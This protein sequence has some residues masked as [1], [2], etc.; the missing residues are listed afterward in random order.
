MSLGTA[1]YSCAVD[2][3]RGAIHFFS[4]PPSVGRVITRHPWLIESLSG[5]YPT[6]KGGRRKNVNRT[7]RL[8]SI[9]STRRAGSC[10]L[11]GTAYSQCVTQRLNVYYT[12]IKSW[13]VCL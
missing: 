2:A 7:C 9:A 12:N 6:Y 10:S 11:R 4:G 1:I 5:N 13:P 3:C 8:S